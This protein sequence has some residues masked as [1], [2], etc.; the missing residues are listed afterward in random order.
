MKIAYFD[1]FSG[2]AG[3]MILGALIDAGCPIGV[4]QDM[5]ARLGLPEVSLAAERVSRHGIAATHARVSVGPAAQKKHRHLPQIERILDDAGLSAGVVARAKDVF[6]RLAQA[7]A[8]VHGTTPEKVHFHE[9]GAADAIIDVV[10]A[11]VALEAL[12]VEAVE[13]SPIPT[14]HGTLVCEH[15]VM[16][17]P[18]PATALLLRDVP[19]AACD[20]EAELI[21]PTGAAVLTT[22]ARRFGPLPAM[23]IRQVGHG[24]G[25]RDGKTR[26]NVLRVMIG[27]ADEAA[28][29]ADTVTVLEASLDDADGQALAYAAQK[30]LDAGAL[31]VA[32]VPIIMKKGRPG[33]VLSVLAPPAEAA[34]LEALVFASTPTL[35]VRRYAAARSTLARRHATIETAFGPIR[36]KIGERDGRV[37]QV[38][39][40]HDDCAAAAERHQASLAEVRAAALAGWARSRT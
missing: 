12:R 19:L 20:E 15:G 5:V 37:L 17:V 40:E 18:A 3:D 25:T 24:A 33:H 34:R 26:P 22:V 32:I 7:E 38:W 8:T 27:D 10:G 29:G 35:G 21:T 9:V 4:L 23:R 31:D 13:C 39:P 16:P 11:A 28:G 1:C 36:V 14:G 6:R 30:L 2:A